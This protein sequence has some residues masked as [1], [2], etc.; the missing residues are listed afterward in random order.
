MNKEKI[1]RMWKAAEMLGKKSAE[2]SLCYDDR[3]LLFHHGLVAGSFVIGARWSD[4]ESPWI[5]TDVRMPEHS[6][7][8]ISSTDRERDQIKVMVRLM[9]GNVMQ[10]NRRKSSDGIWYFNIPMQMRDQITHW[11]PIPPVPEYIRNQN[12]Q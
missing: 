5:K 12:N 11:M 6:L 9:N 3:Q 7:P 1:E 8:E 4:N 10:A 2:D